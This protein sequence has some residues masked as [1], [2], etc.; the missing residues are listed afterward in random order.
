M[1]NRLNLMKNLALSILLMS[2]LCSI[3]CRKEVDSGIC[4]VIDPTKDLPWLQD[5]ITKAESDM[6][7]KTYK[8][9]YIGTIYL[10][11]YNEQ[12]VFVCN[13]MMG[14]GGIAAYVFRC[15]GTIE[16]FN[17]DPQKVQAFFSSLKKTDLI[18]SNVP[19]PS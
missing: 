15:D 14:S 2:I 7:S 11:Y 18:Y 12:P 6:T 10:A 9:N 3:S 1:A 13:M 5:I 17:N 16:N 8:G 19:L 4:G